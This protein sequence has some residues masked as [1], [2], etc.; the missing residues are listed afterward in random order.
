MRKIV[1]AR[2]FPALCFMLALTGC[3]TPETTFDLL[4]G[5]VGESVAD[6]TLMA[7][8][9][10]ASHALAHDRR[11]FVWDRPIL[12]PTGPKR[13]RFTAYAVRTGEEKSLAAWQITQIET[14]P[15]GVQTG[16]H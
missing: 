5:E 7:G 13:C 8:T 4:S 6:A 14:A 12:V 11:A 16:R 9:P 10:V 2:T 15:R 1:S 3:N